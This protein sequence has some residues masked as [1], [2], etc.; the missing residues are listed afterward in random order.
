MVTSPKAVTRECLQGVYSVEKLPFTAE[1]IFQFYGNVAENQ[2]KTLRR[3]LADCAT[4]GVSGLNE[5]WVS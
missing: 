5:S 3:Y 2:R 1:A 4:Q